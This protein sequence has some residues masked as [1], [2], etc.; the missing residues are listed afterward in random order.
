MNLIKLNWVVMSV[1]GTIC[2][3]PSWLGVGFFERNYHVRPEV[4]MMWY[5]FGVIIGTGCVLTLQESSIIPA[6]APWLS[7]V[8]VGLTFGVVA[9]IMLFAATAIAP[10]PGLPSAI[11]SSASA[12]V[13]VLSLLLFRLFPIY[14]NEVAFDSYHLVGLIITI[15][16]VILM[17]KPR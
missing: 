8:A 12:L 5:F 6:T 4:F 7:I 1:I 17:T 9:N 10:N 3:V 11:A 13:F 16:G 14:F 2:I 15:A